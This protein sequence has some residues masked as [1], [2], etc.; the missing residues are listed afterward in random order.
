MKLNGSGLRRPDWQLLLA[1]YV[2]RHRDTPFTW[3]QHDCARFALGW[4]Q[5]AREDLDPATDALAERLAYTDARGALEFMQG[6]GLGQLVQ[7]WDQLAACDVA[8][9]QRGD[10]VLV[11]INGRES[12]AVCVGAEACGPG[13]SGLAFVPMTAAR[14]AWRV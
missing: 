5:L 7:D 14:A 13:A 2:E 10:V 3:G 8:Y 9:A 1:V 6:S 11:E 12:L 4:V